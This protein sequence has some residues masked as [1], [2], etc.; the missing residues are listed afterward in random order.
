MSEAAQPSASARA[1]PWLL[2]LAVLAAAV[3]GFML[4]PLGRW[5]LALV[6][7]LRGAGA[8]GVAGFVVAYVAATAL[9]LPGAVLTLGAGFVYGPLY[10]TLLVSPTSVLAATVAFLLGRFVAREWVAQKVEADRRFSAVDAAVADSGFKVVSLLRLS[11]VIPFN[12][13]NYALGL[14]RV[15]TRDYLLGSWLGMLPATVLYVYLGSVL[16]SASQLASGSRPEAGIW[17]S[18]LYW[19]GLIATLVVTVMVTR[20]A[21]RALRSTLQVEPAARSGP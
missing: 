17:E 13:L 6:E 21:R 10:G 18:V 1:A 8:L 14:T 4:L 15:S 16:T 2:G 3:A 9:A 12:L 11:P 7:W 5:A 20:M 19:G